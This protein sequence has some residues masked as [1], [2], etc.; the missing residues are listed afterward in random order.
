MALIGL[1]IAA[2]IGLAKNEFVDKPQEQRKRKLAGAT[3]RNSWLTGQHAQPVQESNALGTM[4]QYG[5]TGAQMG[6]GMEN[7]QSE[8]NLNDAYARR[9]D[10][11]G[12]TLGYA[13]PQS[14]MNTDVSGAPKQ[15]YDS[16][17]PWSNSNPAVVDEWKNGKRVNT[18]FNSGSGG[19]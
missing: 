18:G 10:S 12:S 2:A 3:E 17:S 11:G 13:K 7:A 4:M 14:T 1:A 8:N 9:L 5:A 15:Q 16:T 6:Q 19:W